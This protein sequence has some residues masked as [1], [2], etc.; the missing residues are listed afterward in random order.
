V[1]NAFGISGRIRK[2]VI[3]RKNNSIKLICEIV[4]ASKPTPINILREM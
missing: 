2:Y 3:P 1:E 4:G